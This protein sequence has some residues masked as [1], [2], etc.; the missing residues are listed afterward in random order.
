MA[1][2]FS[3][4]E[5]ADVYL[6]GKAEWTHLWTGTTYKV[7]NEGL[8]IENFLSMHGQPAVF[9]RDTTEY[10]ISEVLKQFE[11]TLKFDFKVLQATKDN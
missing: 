8:L 7:G 1:P 3:E 11:T 5:Y 10:T 2:V 9:Y 6:P 4:K